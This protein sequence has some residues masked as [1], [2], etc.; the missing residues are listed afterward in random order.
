MMEY[1]IREEREGCFLFERETGTAIKLDE[2][3]Y[4]KIKEI[5]RKGEKKEMDNL[6][7]Q[8][9]GINVDKLKNEIANIKIIEKNREQLPKDALSAPARVYFEITRKCTLRCKTCFNESEIQLKKEMTNEELEKV[10]DQLDELGTFEIRFTGGEPT[11]RPDFLDIIQY[12]KEK[13]FYISLGTNG[14]YSEEKLRKIAESGVDWFIVSLD[15]DEKTNNYIRGEGTYKITLET[16]KY[17]SDRKKRIRLNCVVG[18]YN[19]ALIPFLANLC[20]NFKIESLNLIPLRPY[21]RFSVFLSDQMLTRYE[22]YSMIRKINELKSSHKVKFITTINLL[23]KGNL[24]KQDRIVRKERACAAGI[25]ATVISPDGY[26]YGCS[27]SPASN[28]E[29]ED[30]EGKSIFIAGNLFQTPIKEIWYDSS[31]WDVFRDLKKYK[32]EKCHGCKHYGNECVGSCPIMAFYE[33]R[34]LDTLDPYC[35]VNII[36]QE[37]E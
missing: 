10:I 16:L 12:A 29:S 13:G 1:K 36:K 8:L 33:T 30:K 15:G 37:N 2:E 11:T 22:F 5:I 28:I 20:D 31:R 7:E 18:K 17:L 24:Q 27:Y 3:T 35:F 26:V 23:E 25:E 9:K 32:N 19:L 21:G 4:Q 6:K 34:K 14:I